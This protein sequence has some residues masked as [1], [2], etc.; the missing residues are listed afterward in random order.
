MAVPFDV[1]ARRYYRVAYQ[2]LEDGRLLLER[3]DRTAASVYL[4]GYA[5]ECMLKALLLMSVS[6]RERPL[7]VQRFRGAAGHDLVRLREWLTAR[8][9]QVPATLN[10]DF[11]FVGSWTVN[12]RYDPSDVE[13][14]VAARFVRAAAALVSWADGRI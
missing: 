6:A 10:R 4:T 14:A 11:S 12:L 9:V 13:R 3:L 2:R 5:V 7:V 8:G 1:D